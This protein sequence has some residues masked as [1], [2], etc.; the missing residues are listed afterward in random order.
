MKLTG[1]EIILACL[2]EQGVDKIFG[3]PG[4]AVI[5]LYD[6]LYDQMDHF[7]H[8]LTCHEQGATHAADGYAR[9]TGKVGVCFATSGPGATNTV[10]GIAT[11]YMDSVP[12]VVITGQVP[13]G[14]LGRDSFQEVDITGITLPITKHSYFAKD[15]DKLA[16]MIRKAFHIA[17]SGRPGPVLIDVPKDVF[18]AKTEYTPYKQKQSKKEKVESEF[19]SRNLIDIAKLINQSQRPVIAVGGGIIIADAS[20]EFYEMAVKGNIPVVNTLMGLGSFPRT[21]PLSLGLVGMHGLRPANLAVSNSDLVI[22][23]GARFS[24]RVIGAAD[25]FAKGAKLVHIDIDK[26]EIGKNIDTHLSIVGDVKK[27]IVE[28]T[29][30]IIHK[31]RSEWLQQIRK[32]EPELKERKKNLTAKG[33]LEV[34]QKILGDDT[35]VTTEVGQHQMW[36]AQHWKFNKPRKFISSGGLGTMGYGLGAAI[37]T[38]VGNPEKRVLHI[39]GDGSF[40]MNCNELATVSKYKLPIIT[41]LFNNSAL[42][43]VRQWQNLFCNARYSQTDIT[44]EV[45]Y[46]KLVEAYGIRGKKVE[47]LKDLEE[48]LKEAAKINKATVIECVLSKDD[49]V[50]PM[51]PPGQP[52]D[53]IILE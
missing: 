25:K 42:G 11:A 3:Y 29:H 50:F 35:F 12:L 16:D 8:I 9:S 27:V 45:D 41:L 23:I 49:N 33:I 32:W 18:L 44:G 24:D 48:T 7:E 36:T 4:G 47:N 51:V 34:A 19:N 28:L 5:P 26:A 14:L 31:D 52:I 2:K 1:A 53:N 40:R 10:T 30:H 43:M 22:A 15:V 20:R 37:G 38:Q 46:M 13:S 6:A 21:H 39:A 17:R